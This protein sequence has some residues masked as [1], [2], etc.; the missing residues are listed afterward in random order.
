[1][2]SFGSLPA[3]V[4]HQLPLNPSR[5]ATLLGI[6]SHSCPRRQRQCSLVWLLVYSVERHFPPRRRAKR[7]ICSSHQG[8]SWLTVLI[9]APSLSES[10]PK[11]QPSPR[12]QLMPS[13]TIRRTRTFDHVVVKVLASSSRNSRKPTPRSRRR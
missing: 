12:P 7:F 13:M 10:F 2:S 1:M 6:A 9:P 8:R 3:Q 11:L 5:G 4:G